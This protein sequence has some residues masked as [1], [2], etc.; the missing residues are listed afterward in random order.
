VLLNNLI[1]LSEKIITKIDDLKLLLSLLLDVSID[2]IDITVEELELKGCCGAFCKSLPR[3]R[4]IKDIIINKKLSF[5]VA[6]NQYYV[7]METEF[8]VSLEFVLL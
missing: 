5:K 7:Q 3:Y 6:Y 2:N 4:K 8:N 1:E